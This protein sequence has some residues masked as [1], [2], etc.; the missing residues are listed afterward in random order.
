MRLSATYQVKSPVFIHPSGRFS[1]VLAVFRLSLAA[2]ALAGRLADLVALQSHLPIEHFTTYEMPNFHSRA[3]DK[4]W[5]AAA[6]AGNCRARFGRWDTHFF[7]PLH[8]LRKLTVGMQEA[9]IARTPKAFGQ[10][11]LQ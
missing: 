11:V 1:A 7:N 5:L 9:I 10:D 8:Q 6:Q 3:Q 4:Q 2:P